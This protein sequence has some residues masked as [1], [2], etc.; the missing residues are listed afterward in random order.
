[1]RKKIVLF[2]YSEP[3]YRALQELIKIGANVVAVYT[4]QDAVGE[5]IWFP[6][7]YELA[8]AEGIPV[9]RPPKI[10]PEITEEILALQPDLIFSVYFRRLIPDIILQSAPLGAYNLHGALLPKY[11]GQTCINWAVV[12]GEKVTGA[13]LHK[14]TEKADEGPIV[15]QLSCKIEEEDTSVDIFHKISAL[16]AEII[17]DN[18][19]ALEAGEAVLTEQNHE[20]ATYFPRRRPEF[21]EIH[22]DKTSREIYN[23]VRGV[24]HPFPGAF[25]LAEGRKL[26]IWQVK[27]VSEDHGTPGTVTAEAPLRIATGDGAVEVTEAQW[28]DENRIY[29]AEDMKALG[30]KTGTL[31]TLIK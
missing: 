17:R 16:T 22:W 14:M 12:N 19:P 20:E 24:T 2:A 23:L 3:G 30:L 26:M 27:A 15:A 5:N 4:H 9:Y 7:V 29:K 25:T 1:M 31:C 11:R 18:L 21:G 6:S 28:A 10:T 13:T 8:R